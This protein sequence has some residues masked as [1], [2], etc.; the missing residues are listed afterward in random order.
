[1]S[2]LLKVEN[3]LK[4][5][6]TKLKHSQ[7][8]HKCFEQ[9]KEAYIDAGFDENDSASPTVFLHKG[10]SPNRYLKDFAS[11]A[12]MNYKI[13]SFSLQKTWT[14][15][16]IREELGYINNYLNN[17]KRIAKEE[18]YNSFNTDSDE[19]TFAFIRMMNNFYNENDLEM[20]SL[21]SHEVTTYGHYVLYKE[22]LEKKLCELNPK[23]EWNSFKKIFIHESSVDESVPWHENFLAPYTMS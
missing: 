16:N 23:K 10:V 5:K 20:V 21:F 4:A 12:Y 1:M 7:I 15:E 6:A 3:L 17:I 14:D 2:F 22:H 18:A 9:F 19:G 13:F 11:F 8:V